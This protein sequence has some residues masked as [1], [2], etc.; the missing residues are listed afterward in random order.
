[1][2]VGTG[3]NA[4]ALAQSGPTTEATNEEQRLLG[5]GD[6]EVRARELLPFTRSLAASGAVIGS[7]AES[8]EA[9]G[10][11]S[12]AMLEALRAV[13]GAITGQPP[14]DGDTFYVRWQQTYTGDGAPIGIGRVLWAE[15]R[16]AT[17]TNFAIHRFRP[18]EGGER[19]FLTTGEAARTPEMALPVDDL[20]VSSPFGLRS[21]PVARAKAPK[22]GAPKVAAK[23]MGGP[24]PHGGHR[25]APRMFAGFV[26]RVFMH[27]GVDFAVPQGTPVYA[28][29]DGVITGA[30][31]NGGYGNWIQIDHGDGV[32]T[33]YSH[34]SRFAPRIKPGTKVA[35]GEL[36]A[37]SGNTGRSTGPHLHFEIRSSGKPIDPLTHAAV[38]QLGGVDLDRFGKQVL[39]QRRERASEMQLE[40]AEVETDTP[41]PV[42]AE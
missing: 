7:L 34:L 15:L 37:F 27:E 40:Q 3:A 33:T 22:A 31:P 20:T 39:A 17:G 18:R 30:K 13:D 41:E 36:V 38:A 25:T 4:P 5:P 35:R 10:V 16:L 19:F 12:A 9:A 28:A 42:A 29:S 8:T 1:L 14:Q 2:F 11:P 24:R 6:D 23:A 26:P 32:A 21:D